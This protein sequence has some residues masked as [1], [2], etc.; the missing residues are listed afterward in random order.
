MIIAVDGP[1]ASGKGTLVHTP[2]GAVM[3]APRG[4]VGPASIVAPPVPLARVP[5]SGLPPPLPLLAISE[6]DEAHPARAA[7][8]MAPM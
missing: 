2:S 3:G 1:A 6:P 5:P 7:A 4:I 8:R